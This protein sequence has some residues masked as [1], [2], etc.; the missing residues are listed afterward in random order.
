M[1][2]LSIIIATM[3][4]RDRIVCLDHLSRQDFDDYEVIVRDD[5]RVTVARNE[6][7]KRAN[8]EKLVFL[9]DDSRPAEGYLEHISNLLDDEAAVAGK[10]VHP[11]NDVIKRFT[12][13]YAPAESAK[14]VTRFW[15]CNMGVRREVFDTVGMWDENITWGHE[16]KEL[17]ERVLQEYP[18]FYDPALLVY[19]SYADS[20]LDYWNK[21]YRLERQTP[22]L[23]DKAEMSREEQWIAI[24]RSALDPTNYIGYTATHTAAQAGGTLAKT[25]GRIRG[26]LANLKT[27]RGG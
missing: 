9:D 22:Y 16:E 1:T 3:R 26:M 25:A 18:I 10:I 19:H 23:W 27:G 11:R 20:V 14:Y 2:E 4:P 8:A 24:L 13:H 6:G 12:G 5:E 21:K 17:A 15:G 7:I